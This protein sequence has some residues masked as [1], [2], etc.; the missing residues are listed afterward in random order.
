MRAAQRSRGIQPSI[1][2]RRHPREFATAALD[3]RHAIAERF[4]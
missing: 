4:F 2:K 1:R 3:S